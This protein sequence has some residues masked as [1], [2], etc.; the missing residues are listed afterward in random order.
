MMML[1]MKNP[2]KDLPIG[3]MKP[4]MPIFPSKIHRKNQEI[5][6]NPIQA[7]LLSC[8]SCW[9]LSESPMAWSRTIW[10]KSGSF[11]TW[12]KGQVLIQF[13]WKKKGD[14]NADSPK[15]MSLRRLTHRIGGFRQN[16]PPSMGL[17]Q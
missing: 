5:P 6:S 13:G 17:K 14:Q 7:Q 1:T 12:R 3:S 15:M 8:R 16:Q 4:L 10:T 2:H 11:K 9:A